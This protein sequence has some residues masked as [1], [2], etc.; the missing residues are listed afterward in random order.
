MTEHP[1][2]PGRATPGGEGATPARGLPD[3]KFRE[4]ESWGVPTGAIPPGLFRDAPAAGP[5]VPSPAPAAG[6][7][8]GPPP[9]PVAEPVAEPHEPALETTL[10]VRLDDIFDGA[11]P[12]PDPVLSG[13]VEGPPDEPAAESE[14]IAESRGM[15]ERATP[16]SVPDEMIDTVIRAPITAEELDRVGRERAAAPAG[17]A[18][19]RRAAPVDSVPGDIAAAAD[20]AASADG[21]APIDPAD[22]GAA[23]TVARNSALMAAGTLVSRV[24]GMVRTALLAAAFG[25]SVIGD[26]FQVANT[27]PN[28][29]YILLSA[30]VLNAV[31]IPQI[32]KAMKRPDGGRAFVD[33]LL[34]VALG[35]VLVT[36]VL[37]TLAAPL[38]VRVTSNLPEGAHDA[39]VFFA[40]LCLPQIAF[41]GL[42]TV[43]GQVLN[44]RG[45]FAAFMWAPA[46][47]NVVQIAG[48]VW[49][50]AVWGSQGPEATFTPPMMWL[51]G[52][53][54][55]LGIV[56]Q[57][58]S[59]IVPLYR[60]G[61][62]WTPRF[63]IR[64][65]GL[66]SASK[67]LGW[68]FTALIIAQLGGLAVQLV[69]TTVR[70][71][72][73]RV[74]SVLA[75]SQAFQIFMLPHSFVTVSILTA[76]FPALSRAHHD[77]DLGRMRQLLRRSLSMPAVAV[78]PMSVA[79]VAL[80][81]PIIRVLLP[82]SGTDHA[83]VA[84]ILAAMS[85]GVMA[86]GITTLQ[87]RY[88]FA[89]EDGRTNLWL[90]GLLTGTQVVI[91]L[92][93]FVVPARWAVV[94]IGLGQS[95]ANIITAVVFVLVARR[96]LGGLELRPV[97]ALYA[98]LIAASAVAGA[99][100]FAVAWGIGRL[101]D[102]VALALLQ[103][104]VGG[105]LFLVIV[106]F[107]LKRLRVTE[108]DEVLEPLLRRLRR[109]RASA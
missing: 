51:L 50:L 29:V 68:T 37:A 14:G 93:A 45:Q 84:W 33:R 63:D 54:A 96:Q 103:L 72:D 87:Q 75:H 59:L 94:T 8:A 56:V 102:G 52:V 62:R 43:L 36:A 91:A 49:F 57:G 101:G 74:P 41:Y 26:A 10:Y 16:G 81:Y 60:G 13:W 53:S 89:R 85:L 104:A 31:L 27:L 20:G 90:Q 44:S 28:Y 73:P 77:G 30:G 99:V 23:A 39:A 70:G 65:H 9:E 79:M 78:I 88:C 47:A 3:D 5:P 107:G 24:L 86:F 58:L 64:G 4:D 21:A 18:A 38:L 32:T 95:L 83:A 109:G 61:F 92:F 71:D 1:R 80:S 22:T 76:M 6:T 25:V 97:V 98:R 40:F 11:P 66:G 46:L 35:L 100:A 19:A 17:T 106:W 48:L 55:S 105:G 7:T 82:G 67:I 69:M 108:L 15:A 2:R 12:R 34:T 42:Y